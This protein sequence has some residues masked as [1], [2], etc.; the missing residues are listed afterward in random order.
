MPELP[1]V[2]TVCRGLNQI[3]H[4]PV[5]VE[6]FELRRK[7]LRVPI[8]LQLK[9]Q[10][11]GKKIEKIGIA[12]VGVFQIRA[13]SGEMTKNDENRHFVTFRDIS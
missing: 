13:R 5:E 4:L 3:L 8:P 1:E 7:D 10:L 11:P 2:E 12:I 6:A 9:K